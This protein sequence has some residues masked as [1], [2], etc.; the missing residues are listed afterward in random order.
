MTSMTREEKQSENTGLVVSI[1]ITGT[2]THLMHR[3]LSGWHEHA[4][5]FQS[6]LG[7]SPFPISEFFS[8]S[9]MLSL[10]PVILVV[11]LEYENTTFEERQF[12]RPERPGQAIAQNRLCPD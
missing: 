4:Q 7:K 12:S 1:S 8:E 3:I 2:N 11:P 10:I 6:E 9:A 5:P